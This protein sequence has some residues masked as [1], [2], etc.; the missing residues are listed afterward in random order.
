MNRNLLILASLL[1]VGSVFVLATPATNTH[2]GAVVNIPAQ[3]VE[4]SKGVFDLG[5]AVVEGKVV[6]GYMF[7]H[8]DEAY[9]SKKGYAKPPWAGGGGKDKGGS[10]CYAHLAK[11]AKWKSVE[12]WVV[13]PANSEG[14]SDSFVFSNLDSDIQKWEDE[15]AY[16]AFGSGSITSDALVADESSP[17]GLNE[18]YF[19]KV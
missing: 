6:Q 15:A 14:L 5:T 19:G 7:I 13:N 17:D 11:G 3:A 8:Y 4:V 18:V 1:L 12:S 9:D 10:T 16:N 2:S